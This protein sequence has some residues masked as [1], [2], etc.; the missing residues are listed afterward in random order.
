MTSRTSSPPSFH[1]TIAALA[2]GQLIC[3]GALFY[4]F[5]SFILPMR[6]AL[7]F[8]EP[9]MM[10]GFTLGLTVWGLAT[11]AV[12]AAIDHGHGRA[13][14]SWG[15]LVGGIGF[16]MWS[17]VQGLVLFY[18]A[19]AVMGAAM[20]MTLYDP[21][22]NIVTKRFPERYREGITTLTLLGGLAST[23]SF[24]STGWLIAEFEW[25]HALALIGGVLL[26]V[27]APL[28]AWALQGTPMRVA[29]HDTPDPIAD[30]TLHEALRDRAFWLLTAT[31]TLYAFSAAAVWAHM[32][33]ALAAKGRNAAQSLAVVVWFGPAQVVA[34]LTYLALGR[35][36]SPRAL[37]LI[38]LGGVPVSLAIFALAD[39]TLALLIFA[40]V[41]GVAN[42]L[43]TIVRGNLVPQYFGRSHV[44]RINGAMNGISLLAR[45]SAPLATAWLL[46]ALPGYREMLLVLTAISA[47]AVVAFALAKPP[48]ER[49]RSV[50]LEGVQ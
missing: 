33:P 37:G 34:R 4:T 15:A 35:W 20:A 5:T 39:Q 28:H 11:Y 49:V 26:I 6:Q 13:V 1:A 44:G 25:R 45:A 17:Q 10:G 38:V 19:W 29:S 47:A 43:V 14:M 7:G 32:M 50:A 36:V 23:V 12:G 3:W 42:G 30:A 46:L 27:I 9:Q 22:F 41:F 21:A 40:L 18:A 31:F 48:V 2:A 24:A 16:L 8:S